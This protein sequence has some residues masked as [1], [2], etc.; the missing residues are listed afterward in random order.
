MIELSPARGSRQGWSSRLSSSQFAIALILVALI[1]SLALCWMIYER[2][3]L[4]SAGREIVLDIV[5][6][7]PRSLFRGDYVILNYG[8]SRLNLTDLNG[9]KGFRRGAV[10]FVTLQKRT[11][12]AAWQP[13]SATRKYPRS[14]DKDQVIIR[15]EV[16]AGRDDN[17][18]VK[19][20]IETYF[21]P[22]GQG[23]TLEKQVRERKLQVLVAVG[24]NGDAAIKGLVL[25]G[26]LKY[27]ESLF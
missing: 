1:Q 27:E 16:R 21:V 9:D 18:R 15:G 10:I 19:Y 26:E 22:E 12:Q 6:V 5:P 17:L 3:S 2:I 8:I 24:A 11:G 20:G 13:L 23:K 4:I 14:V 25:D 7:D